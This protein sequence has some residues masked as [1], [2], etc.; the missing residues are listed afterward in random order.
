MDIKELFSTPLITFDV[1]DHAAL[2][3]ALLGAIDKLRAGSEGVRISNRWG[4]HSEVDLF[5]RPEN[6]FKDLC[7][8]IAKNAIGATRAISPEL[9]LTKIGVKAT[10]WI[11]INQRHAYNVPHAH[12]GYTWSGV[13]YV[14]QPDT[15]SKNGGMI[16]FID[17]RMGFIHRD[18]PTPGFLKTRHRVR[19]RAGQMILFPSWLVHWVYPN[20]S[21]EERITIAFNLRFVWTDEEM[22]R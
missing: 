8:I 6:P 17:A 19:P 3:T 1:P 5:N 22:N 4:W 13:Y 11:N 14:R 10:G 21:D 15:D 18:G 12:G 7:A 20:E 16:E 2:N 9:D